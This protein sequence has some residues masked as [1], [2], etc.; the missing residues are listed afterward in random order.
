MP[1]AAANAAQIID[2]ALECRA[3]A[4]VGQLSD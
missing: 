3:L 2:G 1:Q 4:G